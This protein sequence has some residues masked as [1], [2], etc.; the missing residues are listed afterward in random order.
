MPSKPKVRLARFFRGI[1]MLIIGWWSWYKYI[2][3][4]I[5]PPFLVVTLLAFL[6]VTLLA[7]LVVTLLAFLVSVKLENSSYGIGNGFC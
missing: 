4:P 2:G 5:R 1:R 6:V 3:R 7:F